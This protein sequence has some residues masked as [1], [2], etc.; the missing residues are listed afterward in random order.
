MAVYN[1]PYNYLFLLQIKLF[2]IYNE[3]IVKIFKL[4]KLPPH[5]SACFSPVI[6]LITLFWYIKRPFLY[7][8]WDMVP[9]L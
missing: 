3:Y 9:I 4:I 6:Y 8:F 2:R 5:E 1:L 7:T